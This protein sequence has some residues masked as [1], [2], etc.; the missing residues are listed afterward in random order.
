M[1][2]RLVWDPQ[3][4]GVRCVVARHTVITVP[5]TNGPV[6]VSP[7]NADSGRRADAEAEKRHRDE[8]SFHTRG[9]QCRLT[10]RITDPAS[11]IYEL[12]PW[13]TRRV[14]CIRRGDS[15]LLVI[16]ISQSKEQLKGFFFGCG[17]VTNETHPAFAR[18]PTLA[19]AVGNE[20]MKVVRNEH[21][22]TADGD[23]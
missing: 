23:A 13:R 1:E 17:V 15:V 22:T 2:A 10:I 3:T 14:R 7:D 11:S 8:E 21:W 6:V 5:Q 4:R 9:V 19:Q 12:Q 16:L 18:R 20:L